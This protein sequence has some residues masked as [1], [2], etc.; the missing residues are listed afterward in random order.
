MHGRKN[1]KLRMCVVLI[2][3]R[4]EIMFESYHKHGD[5]AK[6]RDDKYIVY[7]ICT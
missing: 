2:N 7:R 6:Q 4:N 1:I 3:I 5:V